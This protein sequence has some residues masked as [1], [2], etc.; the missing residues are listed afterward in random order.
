MTTDSPRTKGD[1]PSGTSNSLSLWGNVINLSCAVSKSLP[2]GGEG[3]PP[4]AAGRKRC[5]HWDKIVY[6]NRQTRCNGGHL[7]SL[8]RRQL[9]L[10]GKPFGRDGRYFFLKLTTLPS[11]EGGPRSGLEKVPQRYGSRL[12]SCQWSRTVPLSQKL[13]V[14]SALMAQAFRV[15]PLRPFSAVAPALPARSAP[16]QGRAEGWCCRRWAPYRAR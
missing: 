14:G 5:P 10:K 9:P 6:R 4:L 11:G 1:G 13:R 16:R 8:L 7:F 2:L 3:G 15:I 12:F